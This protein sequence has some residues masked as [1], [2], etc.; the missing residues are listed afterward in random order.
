LTSE[1]TNTVPTESER[2]TQTV[3]RA[4]TQTATSVAAFGRIR[5]QLVNSHFTLNF[6]LAASTLL[7]RW[8]SATVAV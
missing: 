7:P 1:D 3:V 2:P 5:T 4:P 6:L 8:V